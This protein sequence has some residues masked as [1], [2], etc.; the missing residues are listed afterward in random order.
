MKFNYEGR[1]FASVQNS[2][3]GEVGSDTV[4][5][6]HEKENIVWAEYSGGEIAYG[7]L[8]AVCN[9]DGSLDIRYHHVNTSGD[10]MTGICTSTPEILPD[11]R[12][13][14]HETWQWTSGDNSSGESVIEEIPS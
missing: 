13:R 11:G 10:L 14:L 2:E 4:F 5:H 1:K 3:T 7:H 9:D 6:Y 8:I 12:I